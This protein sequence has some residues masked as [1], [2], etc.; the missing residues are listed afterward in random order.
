VDY[1][2]Q[3]DVAHVMMR[4]LASAVRDDG[5][6]S[7]TQ[8]RMLSAVGTFLLGCETR[9]DE[10]A[11]ITPAE[12]AAAI[13]DETLRRRAVHGM[14]AL[15]IIANPVPPSVQ[16]Q[17][18]D[19]ARALDV[20]EGMLTVARDYS[21]GAM[22]LARDDYIRNSYPLEYYAQ[23][24]A[25]SGVQPSPTGGVDPALAAKWEA[26]ERCPAGSLGR[27]VWDFYQMRHF[28]FPGTEGAV[29]PLLAQHDWVHCLA[30]YGTSA[31]GEIEVF[32]F[33]AGAIPDPKGFSYLVVIFGLFE[34]GY[35]PAVA[36]VATADPGHL[37]K[38]GAPE[39]F[40]DAVRRG[41]LTGVD[42]M[43]GIDWFE[44]ADHP[45]DDARR[46]LGVPPKGD[47][48]VRAGSL[49]AMDPNAVFKHAQ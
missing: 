11:P 19:F 17:V 49:S 7:E 31:M 30:D 18:E 25:S 2:L 38:P 5:N 14:V 35:F 40:A 4:G 6:L 3:S 43:G 24:A 41:I 46:A 34:T 10:L 33:I 47:D 27:T 48:A 8:R 42:V 12:L 39:R 36:G 23:Q 28:S 32:S 13:T 9:P 29:D 26:L 1:E 45:I 16:A 21:Q 15:E 22:D 37:S 20:D 44:R